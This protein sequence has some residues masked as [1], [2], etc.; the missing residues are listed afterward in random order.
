MDNKCNIHYPSRTLHIHESAWQVA[1]ITTTAGKA[2]TTK[3]LT[4]PAKN[5]AEI[6]VL[7]PEQ[8]IDDYIILEPIPFLADYE[9]EILGAS[10]LVRTTKSSTRMKII[11][12]IYRSVTI[13]Y[14][15][16]DCNRIIG[17]WKI[18]S[19]YKWW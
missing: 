15:Y 13:P 7:I 17:G 12:P 8:I 19:G 10:Y 14:V 11:N 1:L 16:K 6:P 3:G 9:H 2:K 5:I 18:N 4:I